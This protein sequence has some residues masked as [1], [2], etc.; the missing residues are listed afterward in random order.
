MVQYCVMFGFSAPGQS[1][2]PLQRNTH[3]TA[4]DIR[5]VVSEVQTIASDVRHMLKSQ[6]EAGSQPQLVSV[7]R[8]L[9]LTEHAPTV[10]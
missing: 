3:G 7:T 9:S 5:R 2:P 6:E 10:A 8:I 4:S 1:P